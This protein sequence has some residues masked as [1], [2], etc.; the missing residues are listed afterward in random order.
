MDAEAE[1]KGEQMLFE[2]A[3][4]ANEIPHGAMFGLAGFGALGG[5]GAIRDNSPKEHIKRLQRALNDIS[6]PSPNL[7]VDGIFGS[8]TLG[9]VQTFQRRVGGFVTSGYYVDDNT[10]SMLQLF[11]LQDSA[12]GPPDTS[13]GGGKSTGGGARVQF[14]WKAPAVVSLSAFSTWNTAQAQFG[15]LMRSAGFDVQYNSYET[16]ALLSYALIVRGLSPVGMTNRSALNNKL[17]SLAEQAGFTV[18][19]NTAEITTSESDRLN[20]KDE[21]NKEDKSIFD[22]M[23][24]FFDKKFGFLGGTISG[25]ALV[26]L[27]VGALFVASKR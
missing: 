26:L 18:N 20:P 21:K 15:N 4:A 27:G 13:G 3:Q 8:K 2:M 12:V 7:K 14:A 5:F 24:E 22:S 23:Q 11:D 25:A 9:A 16:S 10:L 1:V 17:T 6:W 19:P